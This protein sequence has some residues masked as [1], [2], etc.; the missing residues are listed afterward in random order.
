PEIR[1][2]K[3]RIQQVIQAEEKRFG[4]TLEKGLVLLEQATKNLKR[5]GKTVLS[6]DIAFKLY[7]TYGFPL[8]LTEDILRNDAITIDQSG[9]EKLMDEQRIRGRENRGAQTIF[10]PFIPG[11]SS[12]AAFGSVDL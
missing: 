8:D 5:E 12:S 2:E 7:D 10:V 6:G 9:F 11:I 4:E 3:Q 1:T